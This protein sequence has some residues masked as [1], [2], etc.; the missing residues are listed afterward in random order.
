MIASEADLERLLATALKKPGAISWKTQDAFQRGLPD[1]IVC[2][3]GIVTWLENKF[4]YERD[5]R[6]SDDSFVTGLT[7]EQRIRL[8]MWAGARGRA[9]LLIAVR[10]RLYIV[11]AAALPAVSERVTEARLIDICDTHVSADSAGVSSLFDGLLS[12]P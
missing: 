12:T 6:K 9:Y 3:N 1:R 5:I 11:A 7:G 2:V 4:V 8:R 10:G